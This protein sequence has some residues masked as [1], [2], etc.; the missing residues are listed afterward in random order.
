MAYTGTILPLLIAEL[1]QNNKELK[2]LAT[3]VQYTVELHIRAQSE[4]MLWIHETLTKM[5]IIT[6]FGTTEL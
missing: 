6:R 3:T 4:V 2:T 1:R 5:I